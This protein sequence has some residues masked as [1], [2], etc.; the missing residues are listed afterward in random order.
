M[1]SSNSVRIVHQLH[2]DF[3]ELVEYVTSAEAQTRTAYEVE[4]TLFRRLLKLGAQLLRLFFIHRAAVRP[5]EPV[6]APDG[7][8]LKYQSLR[9]TT[10]YSVFGKVRFERHYFHTP[11][12]EGFCP[13]DAELSL[14]PR[15][16]SDLLRDWA[17]YCITDESYDESIRVLKRILALSISKRALEV[18]VEEDAADV[19]A[20]Y[21]QKS[22]PPLDAEGSILVAQA[23]GKGV[24]MVRTEP[25]NQPT[26]RGKG[27]KR[28]K[29]KQAVVTGI[30]TIQPYLR[31]PEQVVQA[32]LHDTED[33]EGSQSVAT[34]HPQRPAPIGK[35]LRA[36]LAGKDIAFERLT[37]RVAQREGKHIQH[38]VALTDGDDALQRQV[39]NRLSTFTLV[40]DIIHASEYL[41]DAANALLGESHPDRTTWVEKHL[42][43]VLSGKTSDVIQTLEH[44]AQ[45]PALSSS[46]RKAVN[47][48]I[49]YYRRNLPYMQ[50]G[51][52]LA[53]G[54]PIGTGVVEGACGHL[55]KDRMER[56]GMRWT[57]PGAQA[58]LDLRAAR[59]NDD[60][61]D[62]Y[63]F[64]R[65]RQHQRLYGDHSAVPP[66]SETI[67]LGKVT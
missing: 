6:Y 53:R 40:L 16:Y 50:Y 59:V 42:L 62:Y 43:C 23:D 60:W 20:F 34:S 66:P 28:T 19:N 47:T 55:V 15:C 38:R 27:E 10:Y 57:Q 13:L 3:Q 33:D 52:Y 7:T 51:Q 8:R 21:E 1:M 4:L 41:W 5:D 30:Y 63:R 24:P 64:R 26:R 9:W 32:L 36:T 2:R 37:R 31:T 44:E 39:S 18:G 48:T 12:H 22:V 67:A 14:P 46:Q 11:G 17:E 25:A 54:W 56:S 61:D 65:Q 58:V 45:S 29:K 35:E 49:G